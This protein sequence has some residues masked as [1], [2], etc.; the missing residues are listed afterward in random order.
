MGASV[1]ACCDAVPVLK[2]AESVLRAMALPVE[3]LVVRHGESSASGQWDAG[4]DAELKEIGAEAGAVVATVAQQLAR[5]RHGPQE[6][7]GAFVVVGL[8][9][10]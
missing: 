1:V 7:G 8:A 2:A 9:R 6:C 4:L 5:L 10:G 3:C